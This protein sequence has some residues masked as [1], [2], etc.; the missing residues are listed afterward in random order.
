MNPTI[1]RSYTSIDNRRVAE[2]LQWLASHVS[3][4]IVTI[5]LPHIPSYNNETDRAKS[6]QSLKALGFRDFDCFEYITPSAAG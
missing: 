5:R 6:L 1:Y 4:S 3:P 2:N